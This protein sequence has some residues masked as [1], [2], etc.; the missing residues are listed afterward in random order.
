LL[1]V[2]VLFDARD[3]PS[4]GHAEGTTDLGDRCMTVGC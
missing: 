3:F 4:V 1:I 2:P